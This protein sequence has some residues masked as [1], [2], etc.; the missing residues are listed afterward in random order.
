MDSDGLAQLAARGIA[1]ARVGIGIG[2]TLAPAA[3]SRLQFGSTTPGQT[4]TVRMLGARDLALGFGALLAA[5]HD[6]ASQRG[7]V[8]AGG[9]ADAIDAVT[10]LRAR[11]EDAQQRGLTILAAGCAAILSAWAA[12]QLT[13]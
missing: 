9:L 6:S 5:R 12:R 8:E 11:N 4:M 13:D 10:F 1:L 3:V 2:A 7:W